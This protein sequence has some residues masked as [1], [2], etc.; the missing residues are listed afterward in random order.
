MDKTCSNC[1]YEVQRK[2]RYLSM[3]TRCVLGPALPQSGYTL[4]IEDNWEPLTPPEHPLD[5]LTR[6]GQEMGDYD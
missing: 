4:I 3:C 6:I 5:E 1:A 2:E